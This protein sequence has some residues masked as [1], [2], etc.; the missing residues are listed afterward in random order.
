MMLSNNP[1][2]NNGKKQR[3][4]LSFSNV[5]TVAM[6][7]FITAMLV[8]PNVKAYV[9]QGLMKVGLF[10]PSIPSQKSGGEQNTSENI[11]ANVVF[12]D[13]KMQ[14]LKLADLK[15][16]VIFI[17]FWATWCPPCIAEMP[18][19][20][21][22]YKHYKSNDNIVFLLVDADGDLKK[23]G[24]FMK[25]RGFD[26]PVYIP[27]GTIPES[28]FAGSLPTTVVLNKQGRVVFYH[29]GSA[30]YQSAEFVTFVNGLL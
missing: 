23:S 16:K 21:N 1:P 22:L 2:K 15:D 18:S 24:D 9:I 10:K 11:T 25:K 7:V 19:I 27:A 4:W 17:N 30:N 12:L 3:K 13:T 29:E 14:T 6:V 28:M 20:N 26:L 5:L 8:N